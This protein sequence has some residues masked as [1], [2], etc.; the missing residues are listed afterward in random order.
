MIHVIAT[1][2]LKPG[3]LEAFLAEFKRIVPA[4]HAEAGCIEYG[5]TI[6]IDSGMS[7]QGPIRES[8]VVIV[9]KW[10]SLESLHA[11]THAPHMAEYRVRVKDF[12]D[13]VTLQIL[14]PA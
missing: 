2:Y 6:D 3:K 13:T 14:T 4:V 11:H 8:V 12:V 9:E 7:V 10:E 5:P 1:I